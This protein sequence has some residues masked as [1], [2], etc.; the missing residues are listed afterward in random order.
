MLLPLRRG[1]LERGLPQLHAPL[2]GQRVIDGHADFGDVIADCCA[3]CFEQVVLE[4]GAR[5]VE[6]RDQVIVRHSPYSWGEHGLQEYDY[7]LERPTISCTSRTSRATTCGVD[8]AD[9]IFVS[10]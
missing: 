9:T 8:L 6:Q 7:S 2:S 1:S 10:I 3:V 4:N 5:S